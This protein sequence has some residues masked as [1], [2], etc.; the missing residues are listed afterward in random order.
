MT[1][2]VN[3]ADIILEEC[4]IVSI[5]G[6]NPEDERVYSSNAKGISVP[7]AVMINENSAS[8]SEILAAS[9]PGEQCRRYC[10]HAIF[11]QG[12]S[13]NYHEA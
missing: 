2:V 6:N 8:A 9:V 13:S 3:I 11:W 1:P 5:K 7:I 4:T 10:R 12:N